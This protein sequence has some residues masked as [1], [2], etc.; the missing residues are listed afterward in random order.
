MEARKCTLSLS[1]L[2]A[3]LYS[4]TKLGSRLCIHV[5]GEYITQNMQEGVKKENGVKL[6]LW[7][8]YRH[9]RNWAF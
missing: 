9:T 8:S 1:A 6:F 4:G 7:S 5:F 2:P 3:L